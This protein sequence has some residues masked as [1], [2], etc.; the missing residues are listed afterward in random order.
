MLMVRFSFNI[1]ESIVKVSC[2]GIVSCDWAL[3]LQLLKMKLNNKK[4]CIFLI[5]F[6]LCLI[7]S[8][9]KLIK[10][11]CLLK[12]NLKNKKPQAITRG[13]QVKKLVSIL[14]HFAN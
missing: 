10:I 6:I 14:F 4:R 8:N 13:F 9:G 12:M 1:L 11:L 2:T 7:K 3:S 5:V